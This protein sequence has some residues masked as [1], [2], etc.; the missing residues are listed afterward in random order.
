MATG[1]SFKQ[2]CPHCDARVPIKD[3]KLIGEEIKCPKCK[4]PF[5]VEDPEDAAAEAPPPPRERAGE[6]EDGKAVKKKKKAAKFD[7]K[8]PKMLLGMGLA[9]VAVVLL[10]VACFFMFGGSDSKSPAGA[11]GGVARGPAPSGVPQPAADTQGAASAPSALSMSAPEEKLV[12]NPKNLLPNDTEIVYDIQMPEMLKNRIGQMIFNNPSTARPNTIQGRWGIPVEDIERWL[13][14]LRYTKDWV[15]MIVKTTKPINKDAVKSALKLKPADA[16]IQGQDYFVSA[17][18]WTKNGSPA[19]ALAG[20]EG[21]SSEDSPRPWGVRFLDRQTVVFADLVPLKDFLQVHGRPAEQKPRKASSEAQTGDSAATDAY[22]TVS[23][24]LKRL[25]DRVEAKPGFQ[26]SIAADLEPA[27]KTDTLGR[28]YHLDQAPQGVGASVQMTNKIQATLAVECAAEEEATALKNSAENTVL[29]PLALVGQSVGL[30]ILLGDGKG[31]TR[32]PILPAAP[33]PG[34]PAAAPPGAAPPAAR[35]AAPPDRNPSPRDDS[36]LPREPVIVVTSA[37][38]SSNRPAPP[39]RGNRPGA[40]PTQKTDAKKTGEAVI[41]ITQ[42]GKLVLFTADVQYDEEIYKK[43]VQRLEPY[44]IRMQGE[45]D[46]TTAHPTPH[47]VAAATSQYRGR[48][49]QFPEAASRRKLAAARANLPY[50]P[51]QRVSWMA[52][53]LPYMYYE[54][55]YNRIRPNLS[56]QD[57]DN[58]NPAVTL[59]PAFLDPKNPRSTWY[60]RY[61]GMN[62]DTAATHFVGVAGVGLD[63]GHYSSTDPSVAKK[64]GVFG[65]DRITRLADITDGLAN[66]ILMAEVPPTYKAPWIAGGGATV[67][68]VPETRSVQPFVSTQVDGR[69]GTIVVMADGSVRFVAENVSDDVFKALCTIKGEEPKVNIDKEAPV[70]PPPDEGAKPQTEAKAEPPAQRLERLLARRAPAQSPTGAG[71]Q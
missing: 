8:S 32:A 24:R 1:T 55:V 70:V 29:G 71:G 68:G 16:A 51:D 60:V 46:M 31:G 15:F 49:Q 4:Q 21:T 26:F 42:Q 54:G 61:P 62:Y 45:V 30:N 36:M 20:E 41:V 43:L 69:R 57:E 58:E 52:E 27:Q 37:P 2:Q 64:L 6:Q 48:N 67:R 14:G 35:P 9:G 53:L 25:L 18:D 50:P 34:A 5:V 44:I 19:A 66:T 28:R 3:E 65:Y 63:A 13:I 59:I 7:L 23:P 10:A 38:P 47:D 11:P 56:W 17:F 12:G 33:R 39:P 40:Q 22:K